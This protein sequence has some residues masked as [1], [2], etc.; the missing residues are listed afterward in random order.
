MKTLFKRWKDIG[1]PDKFIFI[2]DTE[3]TFTLHGPPYVNNGTKYF[4]FCDEGKNDKCTLLEDC[5]CNGWV[6]TL[7]FGQVIPD[8]KKG[9]LLFGKIYEFKK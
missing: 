4:G 3:Y 2:Q 5:Q 6:T 7:T 1:S 8:T 9:R